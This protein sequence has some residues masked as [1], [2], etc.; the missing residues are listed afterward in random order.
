MVLNFFLH[1]S[2]IRNYDT[3][4]DLDRQ[5]VKMFDVE[6]VRV[7]Q[8]LYIMLVLCVMLISAVSVDVFIM[9]GWIRMLIELGLEH[10][11]FARHFEGLSM[12]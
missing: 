4:E 5:L 8:Q 3:Y 1:Q 12:G 9:D 10:F 6:R 2:D 11:F 7:E